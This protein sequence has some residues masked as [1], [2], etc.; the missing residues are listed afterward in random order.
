MKLTRRFCQLLILVTILSF[1]ISAVTAQSDALQVMGPWLASEADA[2][3]LVLD[4]YRESAGIAI[5]Y[6]GTDQIL[7]ALTTRVAAGSPPDLAILPVAQGLKELAAQGA[8][9]SLNSMS[10]AINENF[11]AGWIEQFTIDG[12]IYAIPTRSNVQTVLWFNPEVVGEPPTSWAAFTEHCD[13]VAA[14]GNSCTAGLGQ[15]SWTLGILFSSVYLSTHGLDMWNGL[16]AGDIAWNDASVAEAFNR[17]TTF[18]GD[19]YAAGG[20]VG[21]LGTGLVDGIALVFGTSPDAQFVNA[22]SWA[23]G[24]AIAAINADL[25]EG[26]TI[27]YIAFPGDEAGEGAIVASADVA[28]MFNDSEATAGLMSFLMSAEGQ[29]LF[30]PSGYTVANKHVDAGLYSGLTARTAEL[31]ATSAIGPDIN[32]PLPNEVVNALMEAVGAAIL[33]P[34]S[35]E[36]VLD[37]L[38]AVASG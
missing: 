13:A 6:E 34:D 7:P 12:E 21:A 36:S 18:Y 11:D 10:D 30:A 23:G 1:G 27:D 28:V 29:A 5:E 38:Q 3:E 15:T 8:L 16:M 31:L 37:D 25:V 22:G 20:A 19:D 4:G 26:E 35:I 17:I 14:A 2:F 9:V 32:S 24:I 33:D